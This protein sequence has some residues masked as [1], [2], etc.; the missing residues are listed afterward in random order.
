MTFVHLAY[1]QQVSE[2]LEDKHKPIAARLG[3]IAKK[4]ASKHLVHIKGTD[5]PKLRRCKA[6]QAPITCAD[7]KS[8]N[9]SLHV[10]CPLCG[11][12]RKYSTAQRSPSEASEEGVGDTSESI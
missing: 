5:S 2:L 9:G 11:V 7:V 4:I 10:R 12:E 8:K 3:F 6:C 1:L